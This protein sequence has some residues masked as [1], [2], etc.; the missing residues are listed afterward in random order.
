MNERVYTCANNHQFDQHKKGYVNL[1]L[2]QNKRSK[3]PG[4][5]AA[6]VNSRRRFLEH[7]HYGPLAQ[8]IAESFNAH[9]PSTATIW[10]AGCGEGYYTAQV[11]DKNPG[12]SIYGLDISKPAIAAASKYKT[13][14]FCVASSTHPPYL[15]ESFDG[16]LSVF[17][18]VDSEPFN[19]VLKPGGKVC[20]VAPD[21]DHLMALRNLMYEEVRPYETSKHKTYLDNRF[22]LIEEQR[23]EVPLILENA[24]SVMDLVGMTPHAHRL[25]AQVRERL[26]KTVRL[27]DTG[28][29]K[30]YWFEKV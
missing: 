7:G 14:Q 11:A 18:R 3:A 12:F 15:S 16:I 17:S 23:L 21:A 20:L 29:F 10:D 30:L 19:R 1:L 26:Q 9:L 13:V 4:D 8:T 2:V 6:M 27:V 25:S 22:T 28:C 24:E 5:D